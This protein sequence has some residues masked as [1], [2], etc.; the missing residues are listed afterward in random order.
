MTRKATG[1]VTTIGINIGK[2]SLHL[3]GLEGCFGLCQTNPNRHAKGGKLRRSGSQLTPFDQ[4]GGTVLFEDV[5]VVEVTV[6][7]EMIVNR[8]MGG[9]KFLQGPHVPEH[10]HRPLS[11]SERLM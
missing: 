3:I 9:G 8:G 4:G 10:R 11:S 1:Q 5:A 6:L 7:I 2:N